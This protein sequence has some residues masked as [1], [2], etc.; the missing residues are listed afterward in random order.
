M[1]ESRRKNRN[2]PAGRSAFGCHIR[3][4]GID[5]SVRFIRSFCNS[6]SAEEAV[7]TFYRSHVHDEISRENLMAQC[8]FAIKT[9]RWSLPKLKKS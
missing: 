8:F 7:N 3:R 5:I 9:A 4:F 2:C 1:P 6:D